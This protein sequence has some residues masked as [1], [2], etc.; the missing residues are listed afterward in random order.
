MVW[1]RSANQAFTIS[2]RKHKGRRHGDDTQLEEKG[3]EDRH[4]ISEKSQTTPAG[5]DF[6]ILAQFGSKKTKMKQ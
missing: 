5:L 3:R 6:R 4:S 1:T 2:L